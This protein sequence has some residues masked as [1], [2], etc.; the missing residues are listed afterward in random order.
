MMVI[1]DVPEKVIVIYNIEEDTESVTA[2]IAN[3]FVETKDVAEN[4]VIKSELADDDSFG[5]AH[6]EENYEPFVM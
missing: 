5:N 2:I 4:I 6:T 3:T 1:D